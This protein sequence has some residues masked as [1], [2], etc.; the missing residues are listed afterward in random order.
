MIRPVGS[1][2]VTKSEHRCLRA[3]AVGIAILLIVAVAPP[4][5]SAHPPGDR[6]HGGSGEGLTVV[7]HSDLGGA[8]LNGEVATLGDYAYVGAGT[9]G[10]FAAQWNKTPRCDTTP[11]T[12]KVVSLV[13]AAKP[14]VVSNAISFPGSTVP[15][16]VAAIRV[17]ALT[18]ANAY[19]GDLLA[20]ALESCGA[21]AAGLVGVQFYDVSN[22]AAPVP[23]GFDNR[24]VGNTATRD[25]SLVQRPDGRVLA[26][27][28]NQGGGGGGIQ[29]IDATN[30]VAPVALGRYNTDNG[31]IT[32]QGCRPF[33]FA[34]GVAVNATGSKAYAAYQ[35]QGR[36]VLDASSMAALPRVGQALFDAAEEGN[37]L[38]FVPNDAETAAL[39]T[40]EDP[41]PAR[42]TLTIASGAAAGTYVGCE[43]I[44]GGPLYRSPVPS[45]ADRKIFVAPNNGCS[46]ADYDGVETGDLA[47]VDRGGGALCE[48]FS[49]DQ[50]AVLAQNAGAAAILVANTTPNQ[51]VFSPDSEGAG[52]AGVRIPVV[53]L[54]SAAATTIKAAVSQGRT[55]GT[56]ADSADTWGAL[57]IFGLSGATP[58]QASVV[59][60]PHTNVLTPGDG[61]YHAAD[62]V[63][64]GDQALVAWMS[65][66]LRVVDVADRGSPKAGPFYV[67]PAVQDPSGNYPTVPLVTG[68]AS[69]GSRIVVSDING[70]LYVLA[71]AS[72]EGGSPG[73][74]SPAAPTNAGVG[75]PTA[76]AKASVE[77]G[78]GSPAAALA[79]QARRSRGLRGCLAAVARHAKR[80]RARARR[81]SARRRALA[82]RHMK[83][84]AST[85]RRRCLRLHGRT[86]GR[87]RDLRARA[88]TSTKVTLR[89]KAAGTDRDR[90]PAAR[91][92]LVR[93]SL[94]PIRSVREFR[95]ARAVCSRSCRFAVTAVGAQNTLTV[96][97]L[98][99][100]T[101]YYY[102]VAARD[103]VSGRLGPRSATVKVRTK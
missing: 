89:F 34:N 70:G 29:A 44:W 82:R 53:L 87:V 78:G 33:S 103:N 85:R 67:P 35:D 8:G 62:A 37:S 59:N 57:R 90:P 83:R 56:L 31:K 24:F 76:P 52:D 64:A 9:N 40:D 18:A 60:A 21:G 98:R 66:G 75:S 11:N 49:F 101:T 41:L 88:F 17:K 48:G 81:G 94:R 72:P 68:V 42:T 46:A 84:H 16:A 99:P 25:V 50:K 12:V 36:L 74:G 13:D 97:G 19:T 95:R 38:R 93:Q 65:D 43:A 54:P 73:G 102:A 20:V 92:Y 6:L 91:A 77:G 47:L 1:V 58:G 15:R 86:P 55:A 3:S 14:T 7:G 61:L 5:A 100:K 26:F 30:P 69:F 79:A 2:A 96:S 27:A 22:P 45:L 63:W 32:A 4:P 10:G 28:A 51:L 39:A 71:P 80:E 23:L